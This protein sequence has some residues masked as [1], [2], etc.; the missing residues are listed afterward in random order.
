MWLVDLPFYWSCYPKQVSE[1]CGVDV[2]AILSST[3][4]G[5]NRDYNLDGYTCGTADLEAYLVG[6][7]VDE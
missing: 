7:G 2:S 1:F 6:G 4:N 5:Y 3:G